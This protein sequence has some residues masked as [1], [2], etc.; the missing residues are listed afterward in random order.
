M[1]VVVPYH[2]PFKLTFTRSHDGKTP[3]PEDSDIGQED[4]IGDTRQRGLVWTTASSSM[5][6][7]IGRLVW[8]ESSVPGLCLN[9]VNSASGNHG[10]AAAA[11]TFPGASW[12]HVLHISDGIVGREAA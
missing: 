1:L 5:E 3:H 2:V 10:R 4:Q 9:N 11:A 7:L 12:Q 8:E 6:E